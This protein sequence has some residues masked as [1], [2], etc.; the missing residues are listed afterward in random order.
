MSSEYNIIPFLSSS[1]P[2]VVRLQ[3]RENTAVLAAA[4]TNIQVNRVL[5]SAVVPA[6]GLVLFVLALRKASKSGKHSRSACAF[7]ASVSVLSGLLG[8]L[9]SH[10]QVEA[11]IQTLL[12]LFRES[13]IQVLIA[14]Y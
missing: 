9:G 2:V 1:M 8:S 6:F 7:I 5:Y 11:I 4:T 13:K 10:A 12:S 3:Q 14:K